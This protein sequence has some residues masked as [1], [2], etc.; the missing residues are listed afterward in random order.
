MVL[1]ESQVSRI[2]NFFRH[3]KEEG[4]RLFFDLA[5]LMCVRFAP[6]ETPEKF[7]QFYHR[8]TVKL[9]TQ[10][11]QAGLSMPQYLLLLFIDPKDQEG[12]TMT[13][14]AERM[15]HTTAAATGLVDR[16]EKLGFALRRRS[17]AD[18][19]VIRVRLTKQGV[20]TLAELQSLMEP[21]MT[22]LLPI[23]K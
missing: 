5:F 9:L 21:L 1:G 8:Y 7:T 10:L 4:V 6:M 3:W 14:L 11:Q 2:P 13:E 16:V 20:N 15:N 19:R 17:T 23:L 12:L 18:R 22:P